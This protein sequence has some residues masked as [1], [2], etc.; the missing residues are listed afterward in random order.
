MSDFLATW[1]Y[2][3]LRRDAEE[4]LA[5]ALGCDVHLTRAVC[6]AAAATAHP[7]QHH[8]PS[9]FS[10]DG[11]RAAALALAP[12]SVSGDSAGTGPQL[13]QDTTPDARVAALILA[14]LLEK[15]GGGQV[16][17]LHGPGSPT[18]NG[19]A[20]IIIGT[21]PTALRLAAENLSLPALALH[22]GIAVL[23][24]RSEWFD[25][26]LAVLDFET[27]GFSPTTAR[28]TE[29]GA[30]L[31]RNETV[32]DSFSTL[33]N[34]GIPIPE[35]ITKITGI[36]DALVA[37]APDEAT[38]M[39]QLAA[40]LARADLLGGHN[41][42]DFD[43]KFL[44]TGFR[45]AALPLPA[46]KVFDTLHLA[47]RWLKGQPN[48]KQPQL[49]AWLDWQG[50]TFHRALEDTEGCA[51]LLRAILRSAC[52]IASFVEENLPLVLL[53]D[54]KIPLD[55]LLRDRTGLRRAVRT[56]L[57]A[58]AVAEKERPE[59]IAS[60]PENIF[61]TR[62]TARDHGLAG[63]LTSL[64]R[65]V[66]DP[67]AGRPVFLLENVPHAALTVAGNRL[68][69]ALGPA[70]LALDLPAANRLDSAQEKNRDLIIRLSGPT[71]DGQHAGQLLD[72]RT[73]PFAVRS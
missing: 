72:C 65:F 40:F 34:P 24:A 62:I 3:P 10:I 1:K 45:R 46:A 14:S 71:A 52:G 2:L 51:F 70:T 6:A 47:R 58:A 37:N 48:N 66:A 33:V 11:M 42:T 5:A 35:E 22:L 36:D 67:F 25:R 16:L 54:G 60:G 43:S 69:L 57:G 64:E 63:C 26:T 59:T 8:W 32:G 28:I 15:S 53:A 73:N 18:A 55:E 30:V 13:R 50:T 39:P 31:V 61:C 29:I 56:A 23:F 9:P 12:V 7:A 44:E 19:K 41:Y 49:L 27:T 21:G 17:T 20:T 38:A 68:T 4:H